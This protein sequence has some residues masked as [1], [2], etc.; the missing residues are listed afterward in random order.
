[1]R[2]DLHSFK[3]IHAHSELGPDTVTSVSP[4][5]NIA[6]EQ[7]S[8][9]YSVGIHPWDTDRQISDDTWTRLAERL[10]DPRVVAV[11]ECGLDALRGGDAEIQEQIFLRH[12]E[13]A[14][15]AG[16][17]LIIHCVRRFGRLMELRKAHGAGQ[18]IVH[19]FR[20]KPELAR[21][22]AAMNI[23]ISL[24]PDTP[25]SKYPAVPDDLIFYETDK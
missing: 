17:P 3:N 18:W 25:R 5:A 8:A 23:G 24:G 2:P 22:L 1:M 6:T 16:L 13:L 10:S 14:E 12:I 4:C 11:G 20:G 15:Q 19:G 21:Q 9:W 7:G